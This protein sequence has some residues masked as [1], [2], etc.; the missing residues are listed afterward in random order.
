MAVKRSSTALIVVCVSLA[1][2]SGRMP[3]LTGAQTGAETPV[4]PVSTPAAR[5]VQVAWTAASARYC[6]FGL[7][8]QKLKGDYLAWERAQGASAESVQNLSTTY[9]KAFLT[10]YDKVKETPG[11]CS[12]ARI[13]EIRP[14]INRH[15]SGN[16]EPSPKV[17]SETSSAIN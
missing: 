17:V 7:N 11:Y 3:G 4:A 14:E 6:A 16:Y 2:C 12:K 1:A 15:L 9:D 10:F 13:E 5:A 8:P